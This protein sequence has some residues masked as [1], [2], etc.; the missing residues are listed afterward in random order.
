MDQSIVITL[1]TTVLGGIGAAGTWAGKFIMKALD[2]CKNEHGKAL[3]KIEDLHVEL[4]EVSRAVG[5]LEGRLTS[6]QQQNRQ[7]PVDN[8]D[9]AA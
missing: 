5:N 1:I 7:K 3:V 6:Y 9:E 2:E 8:D 4:K